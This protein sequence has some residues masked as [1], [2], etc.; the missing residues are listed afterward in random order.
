MNLVNLARTSGISGRRDRDGCAKHKEDQHSDDRHNAARSIKALLFACVIP[1]LLIRDHCMLLV[2][3]RRPVSLVAQRSPKAARV[4]A[5]LSNAS[6]SDGPIVL[7]PNYDVNY[8]ANSSL[9]I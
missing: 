2:S 9:S 1:D 7:L 5:A 6:A 4:G 8:G 3:M